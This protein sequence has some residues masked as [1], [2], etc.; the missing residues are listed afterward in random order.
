MNGERD[1]RRGEGKRVEKFE[2]RSES[3]GGKREE[4]HPCMFAMYKP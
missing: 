3:R 4:K 2:R 1:E